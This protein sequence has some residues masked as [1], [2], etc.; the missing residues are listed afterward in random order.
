MST[1]SSTGAGSDTGFSDTF[2][3]ELLDTLRNAPQRLTAKWSER[4]PRAPLTEQESFDVVFDAN[5]A[6]R[7]AVMKGGARGQM[8]ERRA[9]AVEFLIRRC[10]PDAAHSETVIAMWRAG[11]LDVTAATVAA[12]KDGIFESTNGDCLRDYDAPT[13]RQVISLSVEVRG[14]IDADGIPLRT[15]STPEED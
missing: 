4:D 14:W 3:T 2:A 12:D 10:L 1:P 9:G 7:S 5:L 11:V 8:A 13:S 6:S 15:A